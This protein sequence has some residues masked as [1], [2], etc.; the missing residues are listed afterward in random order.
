MSKI[1]EMEVGVENECQTVNRAVKTN[2]IQEEDETYTKSMIGLGSGMHDEKIVKLLGVGWN[3]ESD[4]LFFNLSDLI[5]FAKNLP[6]TKRSLFRLIAKIF[7]PLRISVRCQDEVFVS[8][9]LSRKERLG[10]TSKW[11]FA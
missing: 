5:D 9:Y 2:I 3:C 7:D 6:V 11:R 8:S 4:D 1:E 10:R